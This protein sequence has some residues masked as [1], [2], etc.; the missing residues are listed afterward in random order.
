MAAR[1]K[2]TDMVASGG[3]AVA[4]PW[5]QALQSSG[6]APSIKT[7]GDSNSVSTRG[8]KFSID[9][10]KYGNEITAYI[11][12]FINERSY[13]D[14][15]YTEGEVRIPACFALS[16]TPDDMAPHSKAV[17]PQCDACDNCDL[18]VWGED[19][20]PPDCGERV[21]LGL[22]VNGKDGKP[23][24]KTMSLPPTSLKNF[25]EYFKEITGQGFVLLQCETRIYFDD[26][27]TAA[28]P[29]ICFEALNIVKGKV[30]KEQK[31]LTEMATTIRE[32]LE[33]MI[34]KP[35]DPSMYNEGKKAPASKKK[36]AKKKR[37]KFSD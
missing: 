27:S 25:R 5:M 9:G 24:I 23:L 22:L 15:P 17:K 14:T 36:T 13:Y 21:R 19:R 10:V 33:E 3:K 18:S 35:Y 11:V 16:Y 30:A 2:K 20:T 26:E 34:E 1:K 4:L 7:G 8:S 29:P 32:K 12:T 28:N 37:S 6:K 31:Q